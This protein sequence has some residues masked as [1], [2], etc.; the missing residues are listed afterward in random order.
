MSKLI[1]GCGY[2]GERVARRWRDA[3]H[4]VYVV[5]RSQ[6]RA[7]EFRRTGYRTIIADIT[8]PAS[9]H[10]LP[11]AETV[12]FSVGY[13]RLNFTGSTIEDVYAGGVRNVLA[14]LSADTRRFI[15][16]ST[17]GVYGFR[18]GE[19]IDETTPP[20]PQRSGGR[21]SLSA[22]HVIASSSLT[23]RGVILRLAGIY[24]PKRVP[25]LHELIANE[26]IPARTSGYLNLIH[27]IDAVEVIAA[28]ESSDFSKFVCESGPRIYC[29][30]DGHP[31]ERGVYYSEVA[32]QIGAEPPCFVEPPPDSPR[33]ERAES[34]RRVN[35]SRMLAE[36][37]VTLTYPD[38]RAGL[39]AILTI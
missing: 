33:A 15:Y 24:G 28:A 14:A 29:V 10:D 8:R 34:S 32:R 37:G 26:P 23:D 36:L 5:T 19:W 25:F 21:A 4:E 18:S 31:V 2:L 7:D 12:L 1:F 6:Q 39:K 9:L 11:A 17:T 16:I 30:S 3:G 20:D 13:D 27:V 38:Y 22:E 35:N